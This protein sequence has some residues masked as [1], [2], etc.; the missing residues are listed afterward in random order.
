MND[1]MLRYG[2]KPSGGEKINKR[3]L[4]WV[5][6]S[7]YDALLQECRA[8]GYSSLGAYVREA[9]LGGRAREEVRLLAS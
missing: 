5:T 6:P 3:L 2:R 8:A 4:V 9:K 7:H 1:T